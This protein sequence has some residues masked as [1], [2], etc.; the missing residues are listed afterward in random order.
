MLTQILMIMP[1]AIRK[2]HLS[3]YQCTLSG[4]P[5]RVRLIDSASFSCTLGGGGLIN[6]VQS[7]ATKQ[8]GR[9]TGHPLHTSPFGRGGTEGDGEGVR[10][11]IRH[12]KRRN[13]K[14]DFVF[15]VCV[16]LVGNDLCVVPFFLAIY[17]SFKSCHQF[18]NGVP[19]PRKP[20]FILGHN[21]A[22]GILIMQIKG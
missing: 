10:L 6:G 11:K 15:F 7:F 1:F 8:T 9:H 20:C 19:H 3:A 14:T 17:L 21:I 22:F 18:L 16:E 5:Y 13:S 12:K 2:P 4:N